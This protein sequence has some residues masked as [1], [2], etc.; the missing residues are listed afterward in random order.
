MNDQQ[1]QSMSVKDLTA[2]RERIHD[3]VRAVIRRHNE[4]K[5]LQSQP[6]LPPAKTFDLERERDAWMAAKRRSTLR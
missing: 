3:A 1:L 6:Q 2:L 4:M 5:A